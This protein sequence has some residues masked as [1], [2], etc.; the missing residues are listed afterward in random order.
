VQRAIGCHGA[1]RPDLDGAKVEIYDQ[2]DHTAPVAKAVRLAAIRHDG[3]SPALLISLA[4]LAR[5]IGLL[6]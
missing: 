5:R 3:Y 4:S 2:G 6:R 1:E